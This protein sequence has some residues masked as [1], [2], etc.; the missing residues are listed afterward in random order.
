[1]RVKGMNIAL[2]RWFSS[3]HGEWPARPGLYQVRQGFGNSPRYAY[4]H[5]SHWSLTGTSQAQAQS[6]SNY[7]AALPPRFWRG[8]ALPVA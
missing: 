2:T 1:M 7:T 3:P 5:G 6:F 4:F 8:L